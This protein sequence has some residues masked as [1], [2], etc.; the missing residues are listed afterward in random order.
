MM[1]LKMKNKQTCSRKSEKKVTKQLGILS[2]H[3]RVTNFRRGILGK[4]KAWA[5]TQK[6]SGT[7]GQL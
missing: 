1:A 5:K 2:R 6:Y 4:G 3:E 7:F